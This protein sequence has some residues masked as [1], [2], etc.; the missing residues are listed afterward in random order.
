MSG[1]QRRAVTR[2]TQEVGPCGFG[3]NREHRG[4]GEEEDRTAARV[5]AVPWCGGVRPDPGVSSG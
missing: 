4:R 5:R 3:I 2:G 1:E